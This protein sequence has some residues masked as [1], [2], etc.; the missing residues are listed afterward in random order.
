MKYWIV[1]V[2]SGKPF[3]GSSC[4]V[5][6]SKEP[7]EKELQLRLSLE[8]NQ[9]ET[10][11]ISEE[12]NT[13]GHY[14]IQFYSPFGELKKPGHSLLGA[15]HILWDVRNHPRDHAIYFEHTGEIFKVTQQDD[16]MSIIFKRPHVNPTIIPDRLVKALGVLP[17]SVYECKGGIIIELHEEEELRALQPDFAKLLMIDVDRFIVTS[18]SQTEKFDYIT[19]VFAPRLGHNEAAASLRTHCDLA[20][21]WSQQLQKNDLW[22]AQAGQKFGRLSLTIDQE[23]ITIFGKAITVALGQFLHLP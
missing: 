15:A 10:A 13:Q 19:R 8:I 4:G 17:V 22:E 20:D 11:F 5:F 9:A 14:N 2:F 7:L 18:E 16:I 23:T 1:D 6:L 12:P 21:F 3:S